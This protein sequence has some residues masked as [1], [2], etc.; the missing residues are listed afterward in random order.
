MDCIN[1]DKDIIY[2]ISFIGDIMCE[3]PLLKASKTCG[4]Y[5]FDK[6]FAE[7]K[8]LFLRSDY[9]VGNLETVFAGEMAG[10]TDALYSFNTPDEFLDAL[11]ESGI[12]LCVTAN[13][14]CMDR[15]ILGLRRTL[16]ELDKR[17]M[18]HIGTYLNRNDRD[19]G[20]IKKIGDLKLAFLAY[21]Y[22]T[23]I[24]DNKEELPENMAYSVNLLL[25][26]KVGSPIK[27]SRNN[28][29][30]SAIKKVLSKSISERKKLQI[31]KLLGKPVGAPRMD[32]I[33]D[34]MIDNKLLDILEK[35][36]KQAKEQADIVVLNVH[37]GGQFNAEPGAFSEY[38]MK[39]CVKAGADIVVGHHPHVVQKFELIDKIPCIYSL[40]N[41][42][43]SP[44][45]PY[46]LFEELPQYS[47][48]LHMYVT[49]R[50]K[51]LQF[52]ILKII[53][54]K[55]HEL[56]VIDTYELFEKEKKPIELYNDVKVIYEKF[57]QKRVTE[58]NIQNEYL[59]YEE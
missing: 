32:E 47:I 53:E 24:K 33:W 4:K 27:Y 29:K 2:K 51:K 38:I 54:N 31:K 45:T 16:N 7:T 18:E 11:C 52:S 23:G 10:Y 13:N 34:G 44:S 37:N 41:Y 14:H 15:G 8:E 40:G 39:F 21:T 42:S 30:V 48:V 19:K 22:G 57:T 5:N 36:I 35:D 12:N 26:Q 56:T 43:I 59:L 1:G 9:V 17:G 58:F 49:K 28:K 55:H 6:V 20:F 46:M 50:K 3:L 25:P